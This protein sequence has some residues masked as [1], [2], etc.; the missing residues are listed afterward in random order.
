MK[1]PIVLLA[2]GLTGC[3]ALEPT[4][5]L[6]VQHTSHLTQHF[7]ATD[8]NCGYETAMID[9]HWQYDRL[10]LDI[11]DGLV[12]DSRDRLVMQAYGGLAGPREVFQATASLDV[13][14]PNR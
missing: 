1:T 11:A 10:H 5:R 3:A 6:E 8:Y 14:R 7:S 4:V 12:L 13:W 2:L 9:L